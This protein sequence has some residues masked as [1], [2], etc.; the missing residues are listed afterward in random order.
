LNVALGNWVFPHLFQ[1]S[2]SAHSPTAIRRNAIWQPIYSLAYFFIILLGLAALVAGTLPPGNNMNAALLQFVSTQYPDWVVGLLAGTGVLL[3]LVPG[4]VL[5]LTAGTIFTR[6]VVTP[7]CPGLSESKGLLISRAALVVFAALAVWL[8]MDQ[9][10]SLV[11]IL[12]KAYS[13][14][15]MLGPGVF[16]AFLWKRTTALGVVAGIVVGFVALL[17]PFAQAWWSALLPGWEVGLIAMAINAVTVIGVSLV[18]PQPTAAGVALG[19][20]L[21][22]HQL[23]RP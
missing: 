5:L 17:A 6:N 11:S 10:G 15:G 18:T 23:L 21:H 22:A 2:Y 16:L 14:I 13:A 3:A 12:L 20:R 19:V 4:A 7:V 1:I 9:K 8:S